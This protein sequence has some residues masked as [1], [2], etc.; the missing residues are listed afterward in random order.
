MQLVISKSPPT[1]GGRAACVRILATLFAVFVLTG[2][3]LVGGSSDVWAQAPRFPDVGSSLPSYDAIGFLSS[4]GIISGYQNG[5]FGPGDSLKRGQATKM[6]VLWKGVPLIKGASSFPDLDSTY[7]SYVETACA[8]G[9][10]TG[11]ADGRFKPYSTLTRQQMAIIMVRAMG[12]ERSALALS[13]EQ[14]DEALS[15]FSDR[16]DI[17]DVAVPYVAMAVS[18]G[19]FGGTTVVSHPRR[20]SPV[21][22]S[23]SWSTGPNR[24]APRPSLGCVAQAITLTRPG[25]CSICRALRTKS[26]PPLRLTGTLLSTSPGVSSAVILIRASDRPKSYQ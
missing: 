19:L 21:D 26:R 1:V 17:A 2:A 16:A 11:F 7:R 12:W 8:Q 6:L 13:A 9:W 23:A 22:S 4:A 5:T 18:G 3:L 14:I 25:W 10:I 20:G 15:K 24:A